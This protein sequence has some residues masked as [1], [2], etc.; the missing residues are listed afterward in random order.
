MAIFHNY[1]LPK[2]IH[3]LYSEF[4]HFEKEMIIYFFIKPIHLIKVL[5]FILT[6]QSDWLITVLW[7]YLVKRSLVIVKHYFNDPLI[8]YLRP[9]NQNQQVK[10]FLFLR[11]FFYVWFKKIIFN[12]EEYLFEFILL[13][14][15]VFKFI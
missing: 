15:L 10:I 9:R 14:K 1:D 5:F 2:F 4:L 13:N 3:W 12:H 11:H 8:I 6:A 7:N